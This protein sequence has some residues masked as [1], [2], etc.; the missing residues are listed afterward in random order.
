MRTL[1]VTPVDPNVP[2]GTQDLQ[3]L[4]VV[5]G[6]ES[7]A[8][9]VQQRLRF[10]LGT[11]ELDKR[12][13]TDPVLGRENT[14]DLVALTYEAAIRDEGGTEVTGVTGVRVEL[15]RTT[16]VLTYYAVVQTIYGSMPLTVSLL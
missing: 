12:R 5:D 3:G 11:W 14:P 13:G 7:L 6:L 8:Q 4:R 1:A 2:D 10:P 16:R 9:R 15:D